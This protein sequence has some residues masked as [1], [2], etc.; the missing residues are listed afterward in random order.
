[1]K[2]GDRIIYWCGGSSLHGQQGT[3]AVYRRGGHDVGV[4]FDDELAQCHDLKGKCEE[5]HGWWTSAGQLRTIEVTEEE[6]KH[7]V[8][9]I[10]VNGVRRRRG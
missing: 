4:V 9:S 7:G 5:G 10:L 1:M 2:V 6:M 8:V 3:I